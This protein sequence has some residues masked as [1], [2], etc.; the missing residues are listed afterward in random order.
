MLRENQ[1]LPCPR[2]KGF[3]HKKI[4]IKLDSRKMSPGIGCIIFLLV[5]IVLVLV[6][7]CALVVAAVDIRIIAWPLIIIFSLY[8]L[9]N[10]RFQKVWKCEQ[11]GYEQIE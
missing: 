7:P 2:C 1:T 4:S 8:V 9:S 5:I 6:G 3:M 11:C 10:I